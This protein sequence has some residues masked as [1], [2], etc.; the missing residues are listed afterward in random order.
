MSKRRRTEDD[1][2]KE[3]THPSS[4][5]PPEKSENLWFEDGSIVLQAENT[6][7]KVHRSILAKNSPIFA[8]LFKIPHPASE[9]TIDGCPVVHLQD[10]AEDIKHVLLILYGDRYV[11]PNEPPRMI[12]VGANT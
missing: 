5:E 1:L 12:L 4:V 6:Q 9:P 2:G 7:F 11:E 10:S 8:D 3:S